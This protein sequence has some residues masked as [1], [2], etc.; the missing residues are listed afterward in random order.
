MS[1]RTRFVCYQPKTILNK[2]KR[3]DHWFW[4]RYSA[5]PY[6]GCQHGCAFCYSR[7]RK[8][9]PYKP[10]EN[11]AVYDEEADEFSHLIKV[12]EN[13]PQLLHKA[14]GRVPVDTI[15]TG[16]YQPAERK[17]KLS[18]QMLEVCLELGFPVF[19]LT[20][21]PLVLRDLDLFQ[22]INQRSRAVVAFSIVSTPESAEYMRISRLEG[23]APSAAKR[24]GAMEQV[25]KVG[26]L[27][28]TVAM[29]LMPGLCDDNPNL[30]A[31]A[32]WTAGHGGKFVLGGGL[33]LADQQKKFFMNALRRMCPELL[34]TYE[35]YYPE[36]S[37]SSV[38]PWRM[39]GLRIHEFCQQAGIS[40][41]IPRTI[42]PGE[43]RSLNKKIVEQL[44]NK[45]HAL[46]LENAAASRI[47]AYRKAAWAVEDLEQDIGLI[48]RTLGLKGIESI[49]KIS[50]Q[51]A[52]EIEELLGICQV[53]F[54][55]SS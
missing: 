27:T 26:I 25:A 51:L 8:Y 35:L 47:W 5:Y 21:S 40:D 37:Y 39:V 14:L 7:E 30:K 10:Q 18:R 24:F 33:T 3:A 50:P 38:K 6:L 43:K 55:S 41:R 49:P 20:R 45:V 36:V 23:L 4:T 53:Q 52:K 34:P 28:G 48:D 1:Q 15:F 42:I 19:V 29:P 13:A 31:L 17:F 11:D 54:H 16:D 46:E 44:A 12:K 9:I 32:D 22:D 2:G